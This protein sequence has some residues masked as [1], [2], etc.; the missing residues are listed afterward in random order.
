V[1]FIRALHNLARFEGDGQFLSTALQNAYD[2]LKPGGVVGVVQHHARP[3]MPDEW[4][5]GQNGYL[6]YRLVMDRMKQAG[7]VFVG[8]IDVNANEADQPTVEDRV[9]RL[10]PSLSTSRDDPELREA[11]LAIGESNRMTLKF[12]KPEQE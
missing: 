11:M 7:F 4:A 3:D 9:W 10:P 1:L 5:G 2:V 6:K 12:R 8:A